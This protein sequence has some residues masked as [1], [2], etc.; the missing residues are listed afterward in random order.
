MKII[1]YAHFVMG[2]SDSFAVFF[3]EFLYL[4]KR[5]FLRIILGKKRRNSWFANRKDGRLTSVSKDAILIKNEQGIKYWIRPT[6]WDFFV[7]STNCEPN[8]LSKFTPKNGDIVLDVG[9]NI[10]KYAIHCGNLV[11]KTGKVYAFEPSVKPFE[12]LNKS[13]NENNLDD[14]VFPINSAV[15][16][17]N[18]KSKLYYST[19]EPIA[20]LIYKLSNN[21][22]TI[23]ATTLDSFV[24]NNNITKIDWIK[25]DVEGAEY[26]VFLGA[27]KTLK[28]YNAKLIFEVLKVNENKILNFLNSIGYSVTQLDSYHTEEFT[29]QGFANYFAEKI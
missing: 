3:S 11:G 16:N 5:I 13:I 28:K 24:E 18:G 7:V 15:S 6:E 27:S 29:N 9:A 22:V 8:V 1:K 17:Y 26:D 21:F 12:L 20:S 10:G 4:F 14:I 25:I 2:T 23:D 19:E